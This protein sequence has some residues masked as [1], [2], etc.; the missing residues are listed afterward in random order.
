VP[1]TV[2]VP[3]NRPLS[4]KIALTNH[5]P[6]IARSQDPLQLGGGLAF[7][8]S[9]LGVVA[10][11]D[12]VGRIGDEGGALGLGHGKQKVDEPVSKSLAGATLRKRRMTAYGGAAGT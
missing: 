5:Y 8:K 12:I 9:R 7:L 6:G 3:H 4:G 11:C 10:E 1:I 2:H